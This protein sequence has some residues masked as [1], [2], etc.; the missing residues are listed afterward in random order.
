MEVPGPALRTTAAG[1]DHVFVVSAL[2]FID[3]KNGGG[4]GP[5]S[6]RQSKFGTRL[7]FFRL[8][9]RITLDVRTGSHHRVDALC[10]HF[11]NYIFWCGG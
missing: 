5:P 3:P 1:L 4:H 6:S 11:T 10:K 9:V 8:E 2:V 7:V